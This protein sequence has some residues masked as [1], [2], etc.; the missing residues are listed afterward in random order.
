MKRYV[1]FINES[2]RDK[3]TPKN[4]S[5]TGDMFIKA[6]KDIESFGYNINELNKIDGAYIFSF[7]DESDENDTKY[8]NVVYQDKEESKKYWKEDALKLMNFGW[9]VSI[10][11]GFNKSYIIENVPHET[12]EDALKSIIVGLYPNIDDT[13]YK[14]KRTIKKKEE[15]V[16]KLKKM[17][18]I[19][20]A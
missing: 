9:I 12:W 14:T 16:K 1:N 4:L 15:L 8:V 5:P 3:M 11:S 2:I 19:L 20:N 10:Y 17:R 18:Y 7:I 6:T 13:I